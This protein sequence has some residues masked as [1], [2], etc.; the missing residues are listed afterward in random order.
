MF[1][2]WPQD[3]VANLSNVRRPVS[4][5]SQG[6]MAKIFAQDE[7]RALL[8]RHLVENHSKVPALPTPPP[9]LVKKLWIVTQSLKKQ[10]GTSEHCRHNGE[11]SYIMPDEAKNAASV[12]YWP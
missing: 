2:V 5:P 8:V 4:G 1:P 6:F 10:V 11:L 3:K 7:C 12:F 9:A